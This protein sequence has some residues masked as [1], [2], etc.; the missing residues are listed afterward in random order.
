MFE[1]I[2]DDLINSMR[3]STVADKRNVSH[4]KIFCLVEEIQSDTN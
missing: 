4:E 1:I 2:Q 3:G